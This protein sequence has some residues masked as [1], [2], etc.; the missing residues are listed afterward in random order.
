MKQSATR[1]GLIIGIP[2]TLL[3]G[4]F[5]AAH[6][7]SSS[8][9]TS[10]ETLK[11]A[12]LNTLVA[13]IGALENTVSSLQD[14]LCPLGFTFSSETDAFYTRKYQLCTRSVGT[15]TSNDVMVRV[16]DF[17]VDRYEMSQCPNPSDAPTSI[18]TGP[19]NDTTAKACSA[20]GLAPLV[21]VTW[22]QAAAMCANAGKHLCRNDEWQVAV[23][24]TADPTTANDGL[25]TQGCNTG[26]A[27]ARNTGL[28]AQC[29]SRFGAEDMIGN[30]M[31][32]T[33]DWYQ[34]GQPYATSDG[35]ENAPWPDS[36]GDDTTQNVNGKA[37]SK[38]S[39]SGG[40]TVGIPA[41]GIRGGN[42]GHGPKAGAFFLNLNRAPS[43]AS[44]LGARCC[45]GR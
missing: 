16:G 35:A 30:V 26:G 8:G 40:W 6:A 17:W 13:R 25:A 9:W 14:G 39:A 15:G 20:S 11:A 42:F 41:A 24:G 5:T 36:Y 12:D 29:R 34:A 32:W 7:F 4:T 3:L 27:S 10:G 28:A 1:V 21:D 33:A 23:S 19:A 22:F 45:A 37:I 38:Q 31:E 18:G 43:D 2:L 44:G